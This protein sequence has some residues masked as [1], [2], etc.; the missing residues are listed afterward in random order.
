MWPKR[1]INVIFPHC[2]KLHL[3]EYKSFHKQ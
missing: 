1:S 2:G 3:K